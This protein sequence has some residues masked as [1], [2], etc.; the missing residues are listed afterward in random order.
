MRGRN[1]HE[2]SCGLRHGVH[3]RVLRYG[4][5]AADIFVGVACGDRATYFSDTA[6]MTINLDGT[7][8]S[9]GEAEGDV[10]TNIENVNAGTG[11]ATINGNAAANRLFGDAG[12]DTL[13]GGG[14]NDFLTGGLG[15]DILTGGADN[16]TFNFNSAADADGDIV[17]DFQAG[18]II[19]VAASDALRG[20]PG[21][22]NFT[23]LN[24]ATFTGS[25]Q[26][27][28]HNDGTNTFVEGNIDGD[29][30][31]EFTIQVNGIH[32]FTNANFNGLV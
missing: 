16:D 19:D 8:S 9:G 26:L 27:I 24:R 29:L 22:D 31:A 18:D 5:A 20:S 23:L 7:V 13:N 1:S 2:L 21:N 14:G 17:T 6:V 4:C 11:N 30:D 25:G 12:Q 28:F 15:A 32:V 3:N 10:L